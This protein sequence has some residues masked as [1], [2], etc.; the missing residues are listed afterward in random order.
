MG[1][2]SLTNGRLIKANLNEQSQSRGGGG[3][4]AA[5]AAAANVSTPK[6]ES[7]DIRKIEIFN[8]QL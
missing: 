8:V 3:G 7:V 1:N 4:A 6:I 5:A 2:D